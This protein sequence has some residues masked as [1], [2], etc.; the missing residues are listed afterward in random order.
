[1]TCL[2][3][4]NVARYMDDELPS[5]ARDE[6]AAHLATCAECAAAVADGLTLKNAVRLAANR[7]A[8]PPALHAAL[9]R[10]LDP[11]PAHSA[12][13][14][15]AA[16][17]AML[18]V[19]VIAGRTIWPARV[20]TPLVSELVDQHVVA[21]SSPNPVDVVSEDRHTVKPWFQ[22]RLPFAFNLPEL[23]GTNLQLLGGK[24]T[25]LDERPAAE[26][27]YAAGRHKI[28]VFILQD[29]GTARADG[30]STFNVRTW[31]SSGG[32]RF[33]L[34]TD[35]SDAEASRLVGLLQAAN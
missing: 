7:R 18:V 35:A 27:L 33:Y 14:Q 32:L 3:L 22:G 10:Q 11:A 19:G 17:A 28:S 5:A 34:V 16:A 30:N 2:N 26:L 20:D 6:M 15:W 4:E 21:L 23:A 24:L 29:T 9:R 12:W 1:V 31:S 13:W 8:A 25:Y